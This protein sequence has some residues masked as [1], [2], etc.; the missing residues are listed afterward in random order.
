MLAIVIRPRAVCEN[1]NKL[2][3]YN[4]NMNRKL[5]L[6]LIAF[7]LIAGVS[8]Y[9]LTKG[10]TMSHIPDDMLNV[11]D[12]EGKTPL[13]EA[14]LR[15]DFADMKTLVERGADINIPDVEQGSLRSVVYLS[16]IHI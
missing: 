4:I 16:L 6:S 14:Y 9:F 1:Q 15:R 5:L 13:F 11:R 12:E 10:Q 8:T 7:V 2:V 3:I